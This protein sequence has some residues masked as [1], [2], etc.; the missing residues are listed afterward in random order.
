M[1]ILQISFSVF[2]AIDLEFEVLIMI[3]LSFNLLALIMTEAL[4]C[5]WVLLLIDYECSSW[6]KLGRLE[7]E[8]Q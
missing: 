8:C 4:T 2:S 3:H 1:P 6:L 7:I 5:S